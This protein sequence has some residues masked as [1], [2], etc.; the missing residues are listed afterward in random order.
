MKLGWTKESGGVIYGGIQL[1]DNPELLAAIHAATNDDGELDKQTELVQLHE[2]AIL[3]MLVPADTRLEPMKFTHAYLTNVDSCLWFA[4]GGENAHEIIRQ[5]VERCREAGG[6][7]STPIFTAKADLQRWADYPQDDAT[8]FTT[9]HQH[10]YSGTSMLLTYM[11]NDFMGYPDPDEADDSYHE[12]FQQA[13]SLGGS[14][15]VSFTVDTDESGFVA[16][17]S[18]GE[19][20]ARSYAAAIV[21]TV[22]DLFIKNKT[23]DQSS[24][25][26]K[27]TDQSSTEIE[28]KKE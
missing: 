13:M 1:N 10:F 15:A 17:G 21:V 6:R 5:S 25:E 28:E 14:R 11:A 4:V 9:L 24:T 22:D 3:K 19:A 18:V 7:I 23:T 16:R 2:M 8:G 12:V 26:N 27:T 20:V